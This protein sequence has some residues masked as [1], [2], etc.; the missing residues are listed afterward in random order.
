M[1]QQKETILLR[2]NSDLKNKAKALAEKESMTLSCFIRRLII[3]EI[4]NG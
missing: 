4:T 2:I 3:K 1:I